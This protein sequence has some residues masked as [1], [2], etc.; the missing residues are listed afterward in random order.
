M[1]PM[2]WLGCAVAAMVFAGTANA[3]DLTELPRGS[4]WPDLEE[5]H[6]EVRREEASR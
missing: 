6:C 4:G 3:E 2:Y 5:W 1:K